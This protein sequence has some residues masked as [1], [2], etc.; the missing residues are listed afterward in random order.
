M[1]SEPEATPQGWH[2][3]PYFSQAILDA[4][5][6]NVAVLNRTGEI[7]A[8][9]RSWQRFAE[10]NVSRCST[11]VGV[12]Y[13]EVV[14]NAIGHGSENGQSAYD[15]IRS[16]L[17][18][19]TPRF[20]LEYPCPSATQYRWF[21]MEVTPVDGPAPAAAVVMHHDIT[22][23]KLAEAALQEEKERYR[24]L[25]ELSQDA[26]LIL[27]DECIGYSNPAAWTLLGSHAAEGLLGRPIDP[28]F[29]PEDRQ[30]AATRRRQIHETGQAV[31]PH[32]FR[33]RRLDGREI[34]VE[35]FGTPCWFEGKPAIQMVVRDISVRTET[36]KALQASEAR[37]RSLIQAV[38]LMDW[39]TGPNG[40]SIEFA[41]EW[42]PL[43]GQR[44]E[45][46]IGRGW[47]EV[48]H[49]DDRAPT[50]DRWQTAVGTGQPYE[51]AFRVRTPDGTW[52]HLLAKGNPVRDS[53]GRIREWIGVLIDVTQ[54]RQAEEAAQES[55]KRLTALINDLDGIVWEL[56]PRTWK[57]LYVS[58]QAERILGY[59]VSRWYQ[60]DHFWENHIHPEDREQSVNF[61]V[62]ATQRGLN[63]AF[64]YRMIAADGR[65]VWL[66]DVVSVETVQGRPVTTRGVMIDI[67]ARRQAEQA[68]RESEERYRLLTEVQPTIVW[69]LRPDHTVEFVSRQWVEFTGRTLE[70]VQALGWHDL[71]HPDDLPGMLAT[72]RGLPERGQAY[73]VEVRYRRHD[74]EYRR[75]LCRAAPMKDA[76]GAVVKW[77]ST[78][79]DIHTHWLIEQKLS[80]SNRL[81]ETISR[82]QG[83]FLVQGDTAKVF[84]QILDALLELTE[85]EY[86]FIGEV[87]HRPT[88]QPY[89]KTH[90]ISNIAW[91]EETRTLYQKFAPNLEFSNLH[92]LFGEVITTGAAVI[93]N[94]PATDPRRGGVPPGHPPLLAF[95][96]LPII[97]GGKLIGMV[98][99]AN[100]PGGYD[101]AVAQQIAPLLHTCGTLIEAI[102]TEQLRLQ[103]EEQLQASQHMLET[104]LNSIPQAVFWKDRQS[105][106]LG[107]NV[108]VAKAFGYERPE[109]LIGKTARELPGLTPAQAEAFLRKDQEI[110]A[111]GQPVL[112]LIEE[113]TL[114]TGATI[115]IETNKIPL[116]NAR[117]EIVGLLG[118]W[119]DITQRRLLEAQLLQSQKLEAIGQL[120]GGVAHDFNNLLTVITG[121]SELLLATLAATDP[122][123]EAILAIQE[124]SERATALTRQL[125]AF[126]RRSVL[127]PKVLDLNDIVRE[128]EKMLRRLIGEDILLTVVLDPHLHRVR[129]DRGQLGQVL[130]NLAVNARDAMPQG[131]RL[132]IETR[133]IVLDEAYCEVHLGAKPG[134]YVRLAITDTGSGMTPEIQ[135]R[136]FEPFFTTKGVGKGTG[137]GL[138]VV[139]GIVQQSGGHIEVYSEPGQGTTFKLYFRAVHDQLT[140]SGSDAVPAPAPHGSETVLLVEDEESVR[141]IARIALQSHGYKVLTAVDGQD[142]LRVVAQHPGSIALLVTDLIMPGMSGRELAE[143]LGPRFPTMKTLF[144]SG[145]TD[146]AV[147]RH[148][149]VQEKVAFLQKPFSP[150]TLA[151]KVREVLDAR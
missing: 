86:G 68:L 6:A 118:T 112:G 57:F 61:C 89:L 7:L 116:R 136:I 93:A 15:G 88:G 84:G 130:M 143:Q 56:D 46:A 10:Q 115:W 34:V 150:L 2:V 29:H 49:P 33:I 149:L 151:R 121:Y 137:L 107:C 97:H 141:G 95:M 52:R 123:R 140:T 144:I 147:I 20:T 54:L 25:V 18:G 14:R 70:H 30:L 146:D 21:Q 41:P 38:A 85:S 32:P 132:T 148:G 145:Y 92:N 142:A 109:E 74:G 129:V 75:V 9:N 36:E 133:N 62:D 48:L 78:I 73:E 108:V 77:I 16:V 28:F 122:N 47:L 12:N 66:H 99:V 11:G 139:H 128:T 44:R 50:W 125:L 8:V 111:T 83:E 58:P 98:G 103:A 104:V 31:P 81:L 53:D 110:L 17:E 126:S 43:T 37:Y 106:Y 102:R 27:V 127:E 114:P 45:E 59:P 131:G 5:P 42:T 82:V 79:T 35:S 71:I 67:T 120:A 63:H 101:E 96:G 65:S 138:S 3:S 119:Q 87:W 1:P 24:S 23:R 100:R 51:A 40:E 134:Q 113:A 117:G 26:I 69:T 22:G 124:A 91:N 13:L 60:E 135:A 4:L 19:T 39:W 90:A 94:D 76:A 105:R 80:K 55:E 72:L 64:E